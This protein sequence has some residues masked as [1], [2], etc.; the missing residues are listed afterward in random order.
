MASPRPRVFRV[1]AIMPNNYKKWKEQFA[2]LWR[3]N[4]GPTSFESI[5]IT[6]YI[7]ISRSKT[8]KKREAMHLQK[9]K[10]KPDLDNLVKSVFDAITHTDQEIS[11]LWCQKRWIDGPGKIVILC[12]DTLPL[13]DAEQIK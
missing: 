6:F 10:Q 7:P 3:M 5:A 11:D 4:K 12:C 13:I 8:R 9:H 1:G 2:I